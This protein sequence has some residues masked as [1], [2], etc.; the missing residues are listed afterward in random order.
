[1]G[2]AGA[3]WAEE[4]SPFSRV[5]SSGISSAMLSHAEPGKDSRKDET[6]SDEFMEDKAQTESQPDTPDLTGRSR[7]S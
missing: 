1:M 7:A 6:D 2:L 3:I 4:L 5:G